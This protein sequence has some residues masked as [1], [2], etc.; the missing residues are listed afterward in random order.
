MSLLSAKIRLCVRLGKVHQSFML[1]KSVTAP[2]SSLT[3]TQSVTIASHGVVP[4]G[5]HV[6]T[7][8]L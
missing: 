4:V 7:D 5:S 3:I 6:M 2:V 1:G 8:L